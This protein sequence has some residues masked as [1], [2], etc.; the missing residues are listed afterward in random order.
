[1]QKCYV[2]YAWRSKKSK[3][4]TVSVQVI[5]GWKKKFFFVT[6]Y[7]WKILNSFLR[8]IIMVLE[9]LNFLIKIKIEFEP[10]T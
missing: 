5:Y 2:F 10:I 7:N 6:V 9:K 4:L 1:M 3:T 8:N